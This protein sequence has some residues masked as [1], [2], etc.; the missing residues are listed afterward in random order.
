M[1]RCGKAVIERKQS[2][3]CGDRT[4]GFTIWKNNRWWENRKKTPTRT[5]V[6]ALLKDGRAP[7]TGLWSEKAD[8]TY[9]A[10]IT[11]TDRQKY[12][13]NCSNKLNTSRQQGPQGR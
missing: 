7:V 11:M 12:V 3:F 2:F 4:C 9:D 13:V 1:P 10:V 8:K 6:A 5:I